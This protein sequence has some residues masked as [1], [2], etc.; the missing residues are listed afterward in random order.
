[1]HSRRPDIRFHNLRHSCLS[2][3]ATRGV[4]ARVVMEIAGHSQIALTMNVYTHVY[5]EAKQDAADVTARLFSAASGAERSAIRGVWL[6]TT[7][8]ELPAMGS[9]LV[10]LGVMPVFVEPTKGLE[11]LTGGLQNR[12]SAN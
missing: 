1:M 10:L 12:C 8:R 4:P 11:P 2:L 5:D 6:H 9:S 7:A 3:L